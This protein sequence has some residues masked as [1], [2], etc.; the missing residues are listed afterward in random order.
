MKCDTCL[1]FDGTYCDYCATDV[2]PDDLDDCPYFEEACY[3]L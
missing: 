1:Y 2:W 3:E